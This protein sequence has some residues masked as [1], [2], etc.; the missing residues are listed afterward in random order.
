MGRRPLTKAVKTGAICY[1]DE[2]VEARHDS[3]AILHS[4]TDHRRTLFLDRAG[5]TLHAPDGFML[6]CSYNPAYRSSPQDLK[7]SFRQR[8]VT[9]PMTYLP[10]DQE[11]EVLVAE[12]VSAPTWHADWSTAR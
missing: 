9:V 7:P 3:L 11:I 5:E 10:P 8:F 6:V 4:L 1:L 2:V 12:S